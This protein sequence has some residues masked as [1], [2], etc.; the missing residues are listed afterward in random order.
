MQESYVL[1]NAQYSQNYEIEYRVK[2]YV[3][4]SHISPLKCMCE[5]AN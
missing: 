1:T 4:K 5:C 3:S 2:I